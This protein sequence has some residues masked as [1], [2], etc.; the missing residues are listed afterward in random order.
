MKDYNN[1]DVL[2]ITRL[3]QEHSVRQSAEDQ[4]FP[5]YDAA[6]NLNE[7]EGPVKIVLGEQLHQHVREAVLIGVENLK[8]TNLKFELENK[9][10][11]GKIFIT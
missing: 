11:H 10:G 5:L 8:H 1:P 3:S 2:H 4:G 7:R 6:V 9:G